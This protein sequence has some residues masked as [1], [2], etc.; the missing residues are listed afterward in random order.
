MLRHS[1]IQANPRQLKR[2]IV[3]DIDRATA[4][5]AFEDAG[6]PQ[7]TIM[8]M[9]PTNGHAHY[10]YLLSSPVSMGPG[11]RSKPIEYYEA[12]KR[13]LTRRL[14]G[15]ACYN[16]LLSKNPFHE[17]WVTIW[18]ANASFE[19]SELDDYLTNED[20]AF[21]VQE[22]E[23]SSYGRNC[24]LFNTLRLKAYQV[25]ESF[26]RL[27]DGR[28]RYMDWLMRNAELMNHGGLGWNEVRGICRSILKWT[29]ERYSPGSH[30]T[31]SEFNRHRANVRWQRIKSNPDRVMSQE[32]QAPWRQAGVS[33][34]TWFRNRCHVTV[35]SNPVSQ[36]AQGGSIP[37]ASV[38]QH[39]NRETWVETGSMDCGRIG[40]SKLVKYHL[41][42]PKRR[43]SS[44]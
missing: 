38:S 33:R 28:E 15:D 11:S 26:H 16:G 41:K 1:I 5:Y 14:G 19:L 10:Y 12:V 18:N 23:T 43:F 27:P 21:E 2:W 37:D 8:V 39:S 32:E 6:L 29:W 35:A 17:K 9:N 30:G 3:V 34:A 42:P 24:K 13:G 4:Q 40:Y 20:K 31:S 7:P 25:C 22:P 44:S 36:E